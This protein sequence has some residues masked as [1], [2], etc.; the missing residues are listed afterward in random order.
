MTRPF[1]TMRLI[2]SAP[3]AGQPVVWEGD[4]CADPT[5]DPETYRKEA[6]DLLNLFKDKLRE[7][8]EKSK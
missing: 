1:A 6:G 4:I 5:T 7:P 8:L 2:F 3:F